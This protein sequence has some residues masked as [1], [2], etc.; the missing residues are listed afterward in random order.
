[1]LSQAKAREILPMTTSTPALRL[2]VY[3]IRVRGR[4]VFDK[5]LWVLQQHTAD[6]LLNFDSSCQP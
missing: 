2:N 5:G 1:M 6:G 4:F 3:R